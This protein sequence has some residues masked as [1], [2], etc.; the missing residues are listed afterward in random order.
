MGW[1]SRLLHDEIG[2]KKMDG[3]K[4]MSVNVWT[5]FCDAGKRAC[6]VGPQGWNLSSQNLFY[7][8]WI[9]TT[10]CVQHLLFDFTQYSLL[11]CHLQL[12]GRQ[13]SIAIPLHPTQH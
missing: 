3:G 6:D 11:R 13:R 5:A 8:S 1:V 7:I 12:A 10:C 9:N 2:G 4:S